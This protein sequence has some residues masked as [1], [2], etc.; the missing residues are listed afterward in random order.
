MLFACISDEESYQ[1]RHMLEEKNQKR[2]ANLNKSDFEKASFSVSQMQ[3]RL[4]TVNATGSGTVITYSP[5]VLTVHT[6]TR[7]SHTDYHI[8][9]QGELTLHPNPINML[10]HSDAQT[11]I[12]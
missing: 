8:E 12:T 2:E 6:I 7:I 11:Y 3:M 1:S 5:C 9:P 10:L 4:R